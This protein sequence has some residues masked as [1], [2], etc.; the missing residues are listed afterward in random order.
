M[1][2]WVVYVSVSKM[3]PKETSSFKGLLG[4]QKM[5]SS[6]ILGHCTPIPLPP[7][8]QKKKFS[9][10]LYW[11]QEWS[12]WASK[13]LKARKAWKGLN[14]NGIVVF[15]PASNIPLHWSRFPAKTATLMAF[16]QKSTF[17][18]AAFLSFT[19]NTEKS[20]SKNLE[21]E[22]TLGSFFTPFPD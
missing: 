10:D 2:G 3:N 4:S 12:R 16:C 19:Q 17:W 9:S 22:W 7:I 20:K 8:T 6:V 13:S 14:I 15:H 11:S 18:K 1:P 21:L 5:L